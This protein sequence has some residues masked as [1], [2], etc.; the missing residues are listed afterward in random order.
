MVNRVCPSFAPRRSSLAGERQRRTT[1]SPNY[2]TNSRNRVCPCF[3]ITVRRGFWAV[4]AAVVLFAGE[5]AFGQALG[6]RQAFSLEDLAERTEISRNQYA[7]MTPGEGPA[8]QEAGWQ[9]FEDADFPT[10]FLGRLAG[11]RE[12][13]VWTWP[14]LA[15]LDPV[16]METVFLNAEGEEAGRILTD[17]AKA[18]SARLAIRVPLV[19]EEDV[20]DFAYRESLVADWGRDIGA[21]ERGAKS[22]G[23]TNL[24]FTAIYATN[25]AVVVS[26]T[27]ATGTVELFEYSMVHEPH[28]VTTVWTNDENFVV[29][30]VCTVWSNTSPSL[31]GFTND[32]R[33]LARVEADPATQTAVFT[34]RAIP[35][36]DKI[37]F[38]AAALLADADGDGLT[39]GFET[40]CSNSDPDNAHSLFPGIPDN[41]ATNPA[42][43]RT[44]RDEALS[45]DAIVTLVSSKPG[46]QM[47]ESIGQ[48]GT[49]TETFTDIRGQA[50][51][52]RVEE[53][54]Y[55]PEE[56]SVEVTDA[57]V[58]WSNSATADGHTVLDLVLVPTPTNACEVVVR[59]SGIDYTNIWRPESLGA[60]ITTD[61]RIF[62]PWLGG[63]E[64][65]YSLNDDDDGYEYITGQP[66]MP[67][68]VAGLSVHGVPIPEVGWQCTIS[69]TRTNRWD[70]D[71]YP[72]NGWFTCGPDAEWDIVES[73]G[74]DIRGGRLELLTQLGTAVLTNVLH[75]RGH[76][77]SDDE[78]EALFV[79]APW[80]ALPIVQHESAYTPQRGYR[81][82]NST[83][84]LGTNIQ[85][86][87][88]NDYKWCP[89][90]SSDTN[91]W[92]L[93]QLT[94]PRPTAQQ[95]WDWRANVQGG[96]DHLTNTCR[97]YAEGWI[98]EQERQQQAQDPTKPLDNEVFTFGGMTCQKGT[99]F[100][101]VDACTISRYNGSS[102]VVISWRE[103][104]NGISGAWVV[105]EG[106]R[107]YVDAICAR[108]AGGNP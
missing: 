49:V 77:P 41:L 50:I 53:G 60:D 7:R 31:C 10:G 91:G 105:N 24:T 62:S 71:T 39:D 19:A 26:L 61:V 32:W 35:P 27:N 20:Q 11:V 15:E 68:L 58:A 108:Y 3:G 16:S 72:T 83:G 47:G 34:N 102:P 78:V 65:W 95:L 85:G 66:A 89:N 56:F 44:W 54:G 57:V 12:L 2:L 52:L 13:G 74:D 106:K 84:T 101:P 29:T 23:T 90:R 42:T 28:I 43:G 81:Q 76:N 92:G 104:T 87:A 5:M 64:V 9:W 94:N 6:N 17:F 100:S 55:S 40:F 18:E 69:Y 96:L 1:T 14:L 38:Y 70:F 51:W 63:E 67:E 22:G 45:I 75:I 80:Y 30:N 82:F 36:R 79:D 4:V 93:M 86:V 8:L 33:F 103:P 107:A 98:A 99:D 21:N 25:R 97:A 88:T 73:M 37:R 59:D 48:A 46:W